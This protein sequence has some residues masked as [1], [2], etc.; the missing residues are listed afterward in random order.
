MDNLNW[1]S[2]IPM[3]FSVVDWFRFKMYHARRESFLETRKLLGSYIH[4]SISCSQTIGTARPSWIFNRSPK[5]FHQECKF[6]VDASKCK[7]LQFCS[8]FARNAWMLRA[9]KNN[10]TPKNIISYRVLPSRSAGVNGLWSAREELPGNRFYTPHTSG[11]GIPS[12]F[13]F[14]V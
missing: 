12:H 13:Y 1:N 9:P 2:C 8:H 3:T 10:I 4:M 11:N 7:S 6:E 14:Y 5:V